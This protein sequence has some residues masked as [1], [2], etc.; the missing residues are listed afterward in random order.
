MEFF[1][2][3]ISWI[4]SGIGVFVLGFI[5]YKRSQNGQ[6]Q[7]VSKGSVGIQAGGNLTISGRDDNESKSNK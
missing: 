6:N 1:M 7:K 5:F 3:H 2:K 4:F